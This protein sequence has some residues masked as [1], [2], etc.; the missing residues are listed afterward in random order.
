[1]LISY[2]LLFLRDTG[3]YFMWC[4]SYAL[5]N[6]W[7]NRRVSDIHSVPFA[8]LYMQIGIETDGNIS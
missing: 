8:I 6:S 3:S 2:A 1:M 5:L 7:R 4:I